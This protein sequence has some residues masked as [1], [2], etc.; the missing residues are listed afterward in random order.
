MLSLFK[1]RASNSSSSTESTPSSCGLRPLLLVDKLVA[2]QVIQRVEAPKTAKILKPKKAVPPTQAAVVPKRAPFVVPLHFSGH[3]PQ[4]PA[5]QQTRATPRRP[6][7]KT[8]TPRA[9]SH[10]TKVVPKANP[11]LSGIPKPS[12]VSRIRRSDV[13]IKSP[14]KPMLRSHIP[15]LFSSFVANYSYSRYGSGFSPPSGDQFQD[16]SVHWSFAG[17]CV[18]GYWPHHPTSYS[19][20]DYVL[21]DPALQV[22]FLGVAKVSPVQFLRRQQLHPSDPVPVPNPGGGGASKG[23]QGLSCQD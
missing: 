14:K 15:V 7:S 20:S 8:G 2:A 1:N 5:S 17:Q 18:C 21:S 22:C 11:A 12:K 4:V 6:L 10:H 13:A 16:S 19:S 9:V 3:R 23:T